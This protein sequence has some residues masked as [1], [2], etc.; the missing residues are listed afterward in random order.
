MA[1]DDFVERDRAARR[2][3]AARRRGGS[4][5]TSAVRTVRRPPAPPRRDPLPERPYLTR[6]D[7][8]PA[9]EVG[10]GRLVAAAAA[11]AC[12]AVA[13]AALYLRSRLRRGT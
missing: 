6:V 5:D 4:A 12:G 8:E 7:P 9:P 1:Y 10:L 13:A 2:E 3:R 11:A